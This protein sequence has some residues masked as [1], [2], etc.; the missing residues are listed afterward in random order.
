MLSVM[1][2]L[3]RTANDG[4][5]MWR[6]FMAKAPGQGDKDITIVPSC[7]PCSTERDYQQTNFKPPTLNDEIQ[8]ESNM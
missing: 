4:D 3:T 1:V 2:D 8:A 7:V 5:G 6:A